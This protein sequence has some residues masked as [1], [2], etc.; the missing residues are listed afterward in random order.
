MRTEDFLRE[1]AALPGLSGNEQA[2]AKYIADAFRPFCDEVRIDSLNSVI[3]H[4]EGR[5]PKVMI[6]AHL[7]EIGLMVSRIEEDGA[8]RMRNVGGVDPR[9]LP[10]M[11]VTV[12]GKEKL[13]GVIGAKAPHLLTEAQRKK[14]YVRDDLFIDLG[15]SADHVK[16]LVQVGDLV[17]LEGGFTQ[18]LNGRCAGKT[19]DDRSCVAIM[20]RAAEQL[21]RMDTRA[22]LY[23]VASCQ[24]EVGGYGAMTAGYGVAPDFG[25]V[26]DVTHARTP[27]APALEVCDLD[28]PA[29]AMGPYIHPLLRK[30]LVEVA[31]EINV[32][33]QDEVMPNYTSTDT[34]DLNAV[35]GGVPCI[36]LELPVKYMH[37]AVELLDMHAL[38]E[39]ARLLAAYLAAIEDSWRDE[40]WI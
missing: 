24:E 20:L 23:F 12:Y 28:S 22:D 10:G 5:G 1:A 8:L 19:M 37:T 17:Q 4:I 35:R 27:G 39:T 7:D 25:I 21:Q 2:V 16:E 31:K 36:L 29:A 13:L 26:L 18:L 30:K 33:L 11:R 6:C 38:T 32:K 14:N 3:A 40:L 34:D 9:I 15:M